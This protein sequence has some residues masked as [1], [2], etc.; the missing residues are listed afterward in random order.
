M[1]INSLKLH[2]KPNMNCIYKKIVWES[3]YVI[4]GLKN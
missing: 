4:F 3:N 2:I 1:A